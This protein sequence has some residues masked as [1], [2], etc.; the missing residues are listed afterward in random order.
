MALKDTFVQSTTKATLVVHP[1]RYRDPLCFQVTYAF[2]E[3][4]KKK[5]TLKTIPCVLTKLFAVIACVFRWE[6]VLCNVG[7]SEMS[8]S[9]YWTDGMMYRGAR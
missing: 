2:I 9:E 4:K 8:G 7:P 6:G 3:I 1:N 5:K